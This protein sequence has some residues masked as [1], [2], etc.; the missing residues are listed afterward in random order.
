[1]TSPDPA[2]NFEPHRSRFL[3]SVPPPPSGFSF[4]GQC[5]PLCRYQSFVVTGTAKFV[6]EGGLICYLWLFV[7]GVMQLRCATTTRLPLELRAISRR[8]CGA[9]RSCFIYFSLCLVNFSRFA[10]KSRRRSAA[11]TRVPSLAFRVEIGKKTGTPRIT[12]TSICPPVRLSQRYLGS[13]L[14]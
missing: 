13:R 3:I 8:L 1:M 12:W 10:G 14:T 5:R 2:V 4:K 11:S 6:C 9:L 7:C